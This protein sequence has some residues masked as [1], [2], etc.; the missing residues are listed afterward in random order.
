MAI[1]AAATAISR[2]GVNPVGAAAD[3]AGDSF[4]NDGKTMLYIYNGGGAPITLT[5]VVQMTVDTKAVTNPTISVTNGEGRLV[6]PFPTPIYND[7]NARV[8]LTYSGVGSVTVK[9]LSLTAAA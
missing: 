9:A 5:L 7:A 2:A 3:V 4:A 6:G 1:L 8:N